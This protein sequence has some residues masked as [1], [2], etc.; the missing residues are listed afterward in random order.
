MAE[1]DIGTGET[2]TTIQGWENAI[3]GV[4]TEAEIGNCKGEAF[5]ENVDVQ[6]STTTASYYIEIRGKSGSRHDGRSHDVSAAGNARLSPSSTTGDTITINDEHVRIDWMEL[7]GISGQDD[8][9]LRVDNLGATNEIRIH[10]NVMHG[11]LL[12]NTGDGAQE[13]IRVAD[14]DIIAY[15]YRNIV[16]GMKA[17]GVVVYVGEMYLYNNT[18]YACEDDNIRNASDGSIY[19]IIFKNN[20]SFDS[21]DGDIWYQEDATTTAENLTSDG[22]GDVPHKNKVATNQFINATTTWANTDLRLKSGADAIDIAENL[23]SPYDVDIEGESVT[24]TWDSGADEYI[25]VAGGDLLDF[26]RGV[27]RSTPTGVGV[28]VG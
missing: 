12:G 7:K 27:F 21:G 8:P 16:Y 25:V 3:D 4:L 19:T 22:N 13:G 28:G 5:T 17:Q 1:Y 9:D 26:E 2:Y 23:G 18:V 20:V 15:V 11:D 14:L 6:G 24:G 10:H